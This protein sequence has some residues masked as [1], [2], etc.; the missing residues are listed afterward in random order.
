M[1]KLVMAAV[2]A[3]SIS[4][5]GLASAATYVGSWSVDQGPSWST[6]P[7]AYSG[8]EAAAL[9]FGGTAA[10][11]LIST[12]DN[13]EANI[14]NLAWVSTW[15]GACGGSFPCGTKIAENFTTSTG[16]LYSNPGDTSAYV[17]DWAVGPQYTNYAFRVAAAVPEPA[18]WA[19]MLLGF[20]V[21]GFG[22]RRRREGSATIQAA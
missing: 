14:D 2:A 3:V 1:R 12:V 21:I 11:Y 18:T 4:M 16:G 8:Q 7:A 22:M 9:L 10:D 13:A 5:S 19:M 17:S 6:V 15:G 20:G